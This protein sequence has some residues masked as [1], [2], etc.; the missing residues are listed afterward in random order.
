MEI[1]PRYNNV[2][3]RGSLFSKLPC[4]SRSPFVN[5]IAAVPNKGSGATQRAPQAH[6]AA[7]AR[8]AFAAVRLPVRF[9]A[10][11]SPSTTQTSGL[12]V[13]KIVQK[14]ILVI[15]NFFIL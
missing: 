9:N 7:V 12:S 15:R 3:F 1:K 2:L 6:T 11:A 5:A 13:P 10:S 14:I 8:N 4:S